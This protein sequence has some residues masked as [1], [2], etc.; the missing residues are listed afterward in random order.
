MPLLPPG[1]AAFPL[2][3][4]STDE[5]AQDAVRSWD[6]AVEFVAERSI[7]LGLNLLAAAAIFVVGRWGAKLLVALTDRVMARA[8]IEETLR[9]FLRNTATTA[10]LVLVSVAALQRL[11]VDTT[12]FAAVVA[13]MGLA[14]GL[15][16]QG[17][18]SNFAAGVMLVVFEPFKVGDTV[19]AGSDIGTVEEIGM[20]ST[21]LRTPD[22]TTIHLPNG[23]LTGSR[24]RN[25]TS[26]P[27]RR[28]DLVA[29][30]GYD[31]DLRAVQAFLVELLAAEPRVLPTPAAEVAVGK[32]GDS[33]IDVVVRPWVATAD[34]WPV[35]CALLE[36]IKLGFDERGFTIPY[37]TRDVRVRNEGS[38]SPP[39]VSEGLPRAAGE[40]S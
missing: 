32:L 7:D 11:G 29:T 24:I 9:R 39:S 12:S 40:S 8:K 10:L 18:L 33:G 28:I 6:A 21:R 3:Q 1:A 34:Y 5:F 16:F 2:A 15:A 30:C 31:D 17:T 36:R 4:Q 19:E 27:Q 26:L 25:I 20:F 14:V 22:N 13:A 37:P 38:A 23:Q 35:R